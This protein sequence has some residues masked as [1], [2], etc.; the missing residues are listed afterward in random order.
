MKK[1]SNR[2]NHYQAA[3]GIR[4]STS[5]RHTRVAGRTWM[6][7]CNYTNIFYR[8]TL[9]HQLTLANVSNSGLT[10]LRLFFNKHRG[11][12]DDYYYTI[13]RT[14]IQHIINQ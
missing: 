3:Q 6:R 10:S 11:E 14:I 9:I 2:K 1:I 7:N 8:N 5:E 12:A 13:Q 4:R